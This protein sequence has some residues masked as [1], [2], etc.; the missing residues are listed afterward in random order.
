MVCFRNYHANLFLLVLIRRLLVTPP[1]SIDQFAGFL[2]KRPSKHTNGPLQPS[3]PFCSRCLARDH[4]RPNC[5][6][7]FRCLACNRYGHSLGNCWFPPTRPTERQGHR[8]L[9]YP[10]DRRLARPMTSGPKATTIPL[11]FASF[12]DYFTQSIGIVPPPPLVIHWN[13]PWRIAAPE[14]F[15]EDDDDEVASPVTSSLV[16]DRASLFTSFGEYFATTH[17]A[18]PIP[19]LRHIFWEEKTPTPT[20][21]LVPSQH[22]MA[23]Q[24]VDPSLFLP[25]GTQRMLINGRPIM[26][27][28]VVGHVPRRNNDLAIAILHPMP[29][30]LV[31]F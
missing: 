21:S 23:F 2:G 12:A 14:F 10:D 16:I 17:P 31:D 27:R 3:F 22:A 20:T 24:F 5:T 28:V 19:P 13:L 30:G 8:N 25:L 9:A 4:L 1:A 18:H 7:R 6:N 26:R 15:D 11:R 29:Q